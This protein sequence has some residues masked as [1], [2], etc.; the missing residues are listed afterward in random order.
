MIHNITTVAREFHR[1]FRCNLPASTC[2][3]LTATATH[4]QLQSTSV[5]DATYLSCNLPA[6]QMRPT[7]PAIYQ[8]P[9][10]DLPVPHLHMGLQ[11][12]C[13]P[14][15]IYCNCDPPAAAI[16]QHPSCDCSPGP[17]NNYLLC[18]C[19]TYQRPSCDLHLPV[20]G[21]PGPLQ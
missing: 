2:V 18:T 5:P 17:V 3:R 7:C 6:S 16:Y 12:T 20:S 8:R 9:S 15:A 4:L 11:P 19:P 14:S 13:L 1:T 21:S 10:C